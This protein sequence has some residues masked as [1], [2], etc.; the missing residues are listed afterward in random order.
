M[1]CKRCQFVSDSICLDNQNIPKPI[2]LASLFALKFTVNG[3]DKSPPLVKLFLF[4]I[5]SDILRVTIVVKN[6]SDQ[7]YRY[8][9]MY[10]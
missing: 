6:I 1:S 5:I 2:Y 4:W 8:G 10:R 3:G 7:H 9:V